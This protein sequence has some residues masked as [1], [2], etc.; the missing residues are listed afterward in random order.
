MTREK[1]IRRTTLIGS[2]VN[3][4]LAALKFFAGIFGAS[5]ALVA[6]AA[7]SLSDLA[8]DIIVLICAKFSAK[9]EDEDHPYGHGKIETLAAV[10]VGL[11]LLLTGLGLLWDG[12]HSLVKFAN[13][14]PPP[15]PSWLAL[16]AALVSILV[17]EA[18]YWYT[19]SVAKSIDSPALKANAW[20]HRSDSI[21]SIATVVGVG[22]AILGGS[23][24][25]VLDPLAASLIS[26]FIIWTA[27]TLMKPGLEEL[28]EK[29]LPEEEKKRIERIILDT[30]GVVG[31]HRL[32][33]RRVGPIRAAEVHIKMNGDLNLREAHETASEIERRLKAELGKDSHIGV[34]MEPASKDEISATG[35][36]GKP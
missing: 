25:S 28:M 33:A 13:G 4:A 18:L 32:R 15:L 10:G 6:D 22:G 19:L 36:G 7:H 8:S 9:P 3:L 27:I 21:S 31:F 1:A 30:P 24:W 23:N 20:H 35:K 2:G 26:L 12:V 14:E 16:F 29:S 5:S 34:H 11:L 17:K